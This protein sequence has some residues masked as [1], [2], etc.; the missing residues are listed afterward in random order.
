MNSYDHYRKLEETLDEYD[1]LSRAIVSTEC[2]LEHYSI[3]T[4]E[5]QELSV[6]E[7]YLEGVFERVGL[8]LESYSIEDS[9]T[10]AS[11]AAVAEQS[12]T[13][14]DSTSSKGSKLKEMAKKG[15]DKMK[16]KLKDL[17]EQIKKYSELL[18]SSITGSTKALSNTAKQILDKLEDSEQITGKVSGSYSIFEDTRPHNAISSLSKGIESLSR[19]SDKAVNQIIDSSKTT[20]NLKLY[21][22]KGTEFN[23]DG[24]SKFF[25]NKLKISKGDINAI[26]KTD[27]KLVCEAIISLA[28][29]IESLK[30]NLPDMTK[31]I[32][33]LSKANFSA[34]EGVTAKGMK[35]TTKTAFAISGF[36]RSVIGGYVK[37]SLKI[38]KTALAF[39]NAS[40]KK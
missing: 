4:M 37:Y 31:Y 20:S 28:E 5:G 11:D 13:D 15:L 6:A 2:F 33:P 25:D 16:D 7:H 17:P 27:I 29:S 8:S 30:K 26:S 12:G 21:N 34:S 35:G 9:S 24:T 40:I 10:P 39:A 32:D 19:E 3:E 38:S 22:Y 18:M 23:F 36:Y 14:K 1:K